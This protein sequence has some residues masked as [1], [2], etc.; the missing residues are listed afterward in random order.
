MSKARIVSGLG[1]II[2]TATIAKSLLDGTMSAIDWT[3][4]GTALLTNLSMVLFGR[5]T[6]L[7]PK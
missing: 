4:V 2:T 5:P 7:P 1:L 6:L 3:M